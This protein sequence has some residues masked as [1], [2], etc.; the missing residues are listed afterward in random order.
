MWNRKRAGRGDV[1]QISGQR[2]AGPQL[3][4]NQP[5]KTNRLFKASVLLK[6]S[7]LFKASGPPKAKVPLR[8]AG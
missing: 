6:A 5:L 3:D 2:H 4:V 1:C 7:V 8:T